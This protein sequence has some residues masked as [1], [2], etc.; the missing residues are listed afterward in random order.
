VTTSRFLFTCWPLT[1]HVNGQLAIASALRDRGHE[2]AFVSGSKARPN[3]EAAGFELIPFTHIDEVAFA[4]YIDRLETRDLKAKPSASEVRKLLR[5]WLVDTIPDQLLDLEPII[6]R[7]QPDVIVTDLSMWG[8][9]VVLWEKLGIP[10]ALS[11]TFMGPMIPG[12]DAPPWG[13]GLPPAKNRATHLAYDAINR[14]TQA[15]GK[16]MRE[17]L[18]AI[19]AEHGLGPLGGTVDWFSGKLPLYLVGNVPELDYDRHDLPPSVHYLGDTLWF[20]PETPETAALLD[21]IPTERPWVH[22]SEGTLHSGDPFVLRAAAIGLRDL[23]V[24]AVLTAG[25]TRDPQSLGLGPLAKNIHLV[26]WV[27]HGTLMARCKAVVTAGGA[28]TIVAAL[29]AG[30]PLVIVPTT[31][32]KPDNARRVTEAGVGIKLTPKQCTAAGLRTAV[33]QVL[34]DPS[35][36]A[37]ARAVAESFLKAPGPAGAAELLEDLAP[38]REGE[39]ERV[40]AGGKTEGSQ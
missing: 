24:E 27:N 22:V 39:G 8:T 31:W 3:I 4:G 1:G 17:R 23:P 5:S 18:D 12:P 15:A 30:V 38:A 11:S 6:E 2:V 40:E 20:P 34:G 16:S 19:R 35:Y 14:I 32:D 28:G 13:I 21:D 10:V 36:A 29:H 25:G 37:N 9:I 7:W 33:E 26:R